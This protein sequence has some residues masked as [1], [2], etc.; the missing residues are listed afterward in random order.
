[1][2]ACPF[3]MI[4][5]DQEKGVAQKRTLSVERLEEGRQPALASSLP[6]YANQQPGT[7]ATEACL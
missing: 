4:Q 6:C 3:G 1:M 2:E 5:F 7:M